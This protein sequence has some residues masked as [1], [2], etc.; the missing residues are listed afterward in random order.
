MRRQE[1]RLARASS[2]PPGGRCARARERG[3]GWQQ[4]RSPRGARGGALGGPRPAGPLAWGT[5]AGKVPEGGQGAAERRGC[6]PLALGQPPRDGREAARAGRKGSACDTLANS[7]G[8]LDRRPGPQ[9]PRRA[10]RR[11]WREPRL[12]GEATQ[13]GSDAVEPR[14]TAE[15][16]G[17]AHW[18]RQPAQKP[19]SAR[20]GSAAARKT[21][22]TP[23]RSAFCRLLPRVAVA[24]V[25]FS[26]CVAPAREPCL[27]KPWL[28]QD[29]EPLQRP[30]S[31]PGEPKNLRN[32]PAAERHKPGSSRDH[33]GASLLFSSL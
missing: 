23:R 19:G 32:Q 18:L 29:S 30:G 2:L 11:L 12:H 33:G 13:R 31:P 3:S 7:G 1:S 25:P 6:E 10:T 20:L 15:Q 24:G 27:N 5:P 21:A 26:P 14:T 4:P 8:C 16:P 22:Q 28:N 9:P 17:W